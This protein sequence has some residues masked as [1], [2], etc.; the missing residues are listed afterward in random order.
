[1]K[2]QEK[3]Q[4]WQFSYNDP[5]VVRTVPYITP[6]PFLRQETEQMYLRE[7]FPFR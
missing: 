6:M 3:K 5:K 7:L 4:I 1:M 2:I